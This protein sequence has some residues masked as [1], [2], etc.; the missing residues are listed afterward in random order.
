MPK[1]STHLVISQHR[2]LHFAE[3]LEVG[4]DIL[5]T[6]SSAQATHKNLFGSHHKF[7]IGLPRNGD[8]FSG[9]IISI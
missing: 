2:L 9:D 3:L 7:W 6:G 5:Q 1:P 4:L 8:L